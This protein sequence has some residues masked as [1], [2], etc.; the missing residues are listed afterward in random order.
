M[1]LIVVGGW[2]D[3]FL[4]ILIFYRGQY[5]RCGR[6]T[7]K[8]YGEFRNPDFWG[9]ISIWDGKNRGVRDP[10]HYYSEKRPATK[11]LAFM[12][13]GSLNPRMNALIFSDRVIPGT[14]LQRQH[15]LGIPSP[16]YRKIWGAHPCRRQYLRLTLD[17][18]W[19]IIHLFCQAE[20]GI[21][22]V[23][24][25]PITTVKD[26]EIHVVGSRLTHHL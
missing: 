12:D 24:P 8:F 16:I 20:V 26:R 25:R 10:P 14:P 7:R 21:F 6:P 18:A 5:F 19:D 23:D 1:I 13:R 15:P 3:F 2:L 9:H 17:D 4:K 22:A 11:F